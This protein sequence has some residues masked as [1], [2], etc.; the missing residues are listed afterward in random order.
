MDFLE[1][2]SINLSFKG[3]QV[4]SDIYLRCQTGDIVGLLGRN[5]AGK[6]SLMKIIFGS[7]NAQ[8][9]SVRFNGKYTHQLFK[10]LGAINYLPQN[11]FA[12]GYFSFYDLI[13][14][15]G[16]ENRVDEFREIEEIRKNLNQKMRDLSGGIKRLMEIVTI[17]YTNNSFVILDEPFSHLSP[18]LVEKLIPHIKEQAKFKGIILSDHKYKTVMSVCNKYYLLSSGTLREIEGEKSLAD[19]GYIASLT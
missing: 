13:Q 5:G 11:G 4:L 16:L 12:M 8:N 10:T 9:Q 6:T 7:L 2:D 18:L 17:L 14:A 1:I 19:Y 15:F 3:R